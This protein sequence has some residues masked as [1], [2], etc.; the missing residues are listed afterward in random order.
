MILNE[1]I[2]KGIYDPIK[3]KVPA[4]KEYMIFMF[5][6]HMCFV[7]GSRSEADKKMPYDDVMAELL[8]RV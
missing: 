6:E 3:K 5:E 7:V 8:Y 4:F 2:V 1:K